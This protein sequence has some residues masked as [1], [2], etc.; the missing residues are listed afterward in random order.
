MYL[1]LLLLVCVMDAHFNLLTKTTDRVCQ[2]ACKCGIITSFPGHYCS[3]LTF[4]DWELS[5]LPELWEVAVDTA[6]S[7]IPPSEV[8]KVTS[9]AGS[10]SILPNTKLYKMGLKEVFFLENRYM[11]VENLQLW[12]S[13]VQLL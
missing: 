10:E 8:G 4:R 12:V 2:M 3:E 5:I 13:L 1:A 9:D 6:L 11:L 7:F